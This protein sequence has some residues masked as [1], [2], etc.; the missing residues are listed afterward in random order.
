ME[1]TTEDL[2]V[3]G[4]WVGVAECHDMS[5]LGVDDFSLTGF[6]ALDHWPRAGSTHSDASKPGSIPNP[7]LET[8]DSL[9][10]GWTLL[11][12]LPGLL[13]LP[14]SGKA[15]LTLASALL[16]HSGLVPSSASWRARFVSVC[17]A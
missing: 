3:S 6:D 16:G 2:W 12:F 7:C 5:L 11:F 13:V 10:W 14:T 1:S 17:C 9:A 8:H 15:S 4:G